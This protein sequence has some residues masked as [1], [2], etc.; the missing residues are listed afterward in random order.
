MLLL[1]YQRI[2]FIS[3]LLFLEL[4]SRFFSFPLR[5]EVRDFKHKQI[6]AFGTLLVELQP[7]KARFI[8]N[9]LLP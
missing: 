4:E 2:D 8:L 1:L 7:F 5:C 6:P 9:G 3:K